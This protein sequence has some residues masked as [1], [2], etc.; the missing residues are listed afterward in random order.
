MKRWLIK[1]E[2]PNNVVRLPDNAVVLGYHLPQDEDD[3]VILTYM[4]PMIDEEIEARLSD[5]QI[6]LR[7]KCVAIVEDSIHPDDSHKRRTLENE[8]DVVDEMAMRDP[9]TAD[10]GF[11]LGLMGHIKNYKPSEVDGVRQ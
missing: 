7:R 4:V 9:E 8:L 5:T 10:Y 11:I 3:E 2:M 1:E 6:E